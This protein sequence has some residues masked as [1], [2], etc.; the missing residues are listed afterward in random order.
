MV[1]END[2]IQSRPHEAGGAGGVVAPP[3]SFNTEL[4]PISSA[5]KNILEVLDGNSGFCKLLQ[6]I[7]GFIVLQFLDREI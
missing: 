5:H 6:A 2:S 4:C 7:F 1:I 3:I